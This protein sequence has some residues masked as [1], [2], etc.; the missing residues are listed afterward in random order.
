M[1]FALCLSQCQVMWT[2]ERTLFHLGLLV[3]RAPAEFDCMQ[4]SYGMISLFWCCF[5]WLQATSTWVG[6]GYGSHN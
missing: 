1:T 4:I 3:F 6:P 5:V 2:V